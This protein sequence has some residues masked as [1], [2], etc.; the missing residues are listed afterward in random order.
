MNRKLYRV[1]KYT[2][3]L[4]EGGREGGREGGK[5]GNVHSSAHGEWV[6]ACRGGATIT[7]ATA[8]VQVSCN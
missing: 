5:S 7:E 1:R 4:C 3:Y 2:T 6:P 8:S